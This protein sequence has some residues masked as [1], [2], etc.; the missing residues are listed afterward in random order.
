MNIPKLEIKKPSTLKELFFTEP[1]LSQ[2]KFFLSSKDISKRQAS[3]VILTCMG[4]SNKNI[5]EALCVTEK[6]VKCHLT[7]VF[8]K[9]KIN[10]RGELLWALPMLD[11]IKNHLYLLK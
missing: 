11:L 7:V 8:K 5:A 6:T 3:V 9:L 10:H 4:L 2:V 1:V